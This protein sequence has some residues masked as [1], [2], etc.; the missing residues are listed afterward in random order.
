MSIPALYERKSANWSYVQL[1]AI[2][3]I[4]SSKLLYGLVGPPNLLKN[5]FSFAVLSLSI[6]SYYYFSNL[7]L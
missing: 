6:K 2:K 7:Y 4:K 1:P 3:V 5:N